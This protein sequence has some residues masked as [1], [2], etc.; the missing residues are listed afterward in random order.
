MKKHLKTYVS[1]FKDISN[2]GSWIIDEHNWKR[3]K[4]DIG[5]V[6][7]LGGR[8]RQATFDVPWL[9]KQDQVKTSRLVVTAL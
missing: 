6:I 2:M 3:Q 4:S 5:I 1:Y 9:S 7:R 8:K